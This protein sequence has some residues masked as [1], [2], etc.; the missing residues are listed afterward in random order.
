MK[1][2]KLIKL[3]NGWFSPETPPELSADCWRHEDPFI[4][5]DIYGDVYT[6]F[7]ARI[8]VI[9]NIIPKA[10]PVWWVK[11]SYSL[12]DEK[13]VDIV[14]WKYLPIPYPSMSKIC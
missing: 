12:M 11:Q 8:D 5:T 2:Q 3:S 4:I 7:Y 10:N 14:A 13:I 1:K 6:A 9:G